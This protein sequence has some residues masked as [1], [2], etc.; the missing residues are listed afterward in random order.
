M[1]GFNFVVLGE[2][3][4]VSE[5]RDST[6]QYLTSMRKAVPRSFGIIERRVP[7]RPE[8]KELARP[9]NELAAIGC[10][11]EDD[12]QPTEPSRFLDHEFSPVTILNVCRV[13]HGH[14][15][16]EIRP[17]VSTRPLEPHLELRVV[18]GRVAS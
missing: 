12:A 16:Q 11:S 18:A 3:T 7:C 10:V 9:G 2:P 13:N 5:P 1:F 17:R 4:A 14:Q 6:I 15:D 8:P